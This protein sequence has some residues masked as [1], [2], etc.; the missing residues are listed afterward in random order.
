[1]SSLTWAIN[2]LWNEVVKLTWDQTI[3]WKKIFSTPVSW[4]TPVANT[5]LT[6]KDYVDSKVWATSSNITW[7][8]LCPTTISDIKNS[9]T[10]SNAVKV[11][12]DMWNGYRLPTFE[13]LSCFINT[14]LSWSNSNSLLTRTSYWINYLSIML[15]SWYIETV[16][17]WTAKY[18]R[19]VK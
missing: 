3:S 11:C 4:V 6:T 12:R 15:S 14:P 16:P 17:Y 7:G 8:Q 2:T 10:I 18:Y 9:D 1:M 13:E 19:C 5:D